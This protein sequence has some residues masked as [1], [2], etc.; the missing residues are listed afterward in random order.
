MK[1]EF[2]KLSDDY[3]GNPE[4]LYTVSNNYYC[5]DLNNFFKEH[6]GLGIP[7]SI[8]INGVFLE[9]NFYKYENKI[10]TVDN[11]YQ[12]FPSDRI[13]VIFT[14][15]NENSGLISQYQLNRFSVV[16]DTSIDLIEPLLVGKNEEVIAIIVNGVIYYKDLFSIDGEIVT[17]NDYRPDDKDVIS[18]LILEK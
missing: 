6:R 12:V 10:I 9:R 14:S 2:I 3:K 5:I 17:L 4:N 11:N 16:D 8:F 18:V 15:S 1:Y 13:Y 7:I